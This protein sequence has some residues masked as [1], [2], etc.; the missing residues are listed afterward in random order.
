MLTT[1]PPCQHSTK[2]ANSHFSSRAQSVLR[3]KYSCM[4]RQGQPASARQQQHRD[5]PA[6]TQTCVASKMLVRT[7]IVNNAMAA[8]GMSAWSA[9]VQC[10][11]TAGSWFDLKILAMASVITR[12]CHACCSTAGNW[13]RQARPRCHDVTC[14]L[15]VRPHRCSSANRRCTQKSRI[16]NV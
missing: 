3:S 16:A 4:S 11:T 9:R 10:L 13:S 14:W 6:L 12:S 7:T 15:D 8:C 5:R 1:L 2:L